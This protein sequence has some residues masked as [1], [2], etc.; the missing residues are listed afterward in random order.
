M[1]YETTPL[2][3]MSSGEYVPN[4][5]ANALM[6]SVDKNMF[7]TAQQGGVPVDFTRFINEQ[8]NKPAI[9]TKVYKRKHPPLA[10]DSAE[11]AGPRWVPST[12][13]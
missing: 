13:N 5:A 11:R 2:G 6:R 8:S 3:I 12:S 9:Q 7:I 10:D 4:A 1:Q